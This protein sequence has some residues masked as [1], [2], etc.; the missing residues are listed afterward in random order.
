[1]ITLPPWAVPRA[2][3]PS[4]VDAGGVMRS[5]LNTAALRVERPGSHY[6]IALSYPPFAPREGRVI[7]SRLIRAQ[8]EGLRVEY[9]L[10]ER[11]C[12]SYDAVVDGAGQAGTTLLVRGMMPDDL[13]REGFW[14]SIE[15]ARGQHFLHNAAAEVQP[16]PDG[17]VAIALSEALRAPFADGAKVHLIQ[18]M[19]EGLVQGDERAWE[20]SVDHQT[21]L[22]FTIEET[23]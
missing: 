10:F 18:P 22:S 1:M 5:P 2:A 3:T 11:Q 15:N 16:D 14:L 6:R 17:R 4:L 23:R 13:V 7:V 20:M 8:R 12:A 9:P 21:S 19:I